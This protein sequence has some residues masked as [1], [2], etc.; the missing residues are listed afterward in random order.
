MNCDAA[1]PLLNLLVDDALDNADTVLVQEHLSNCLHCQWEWNELTWLHKRLRNF[2]NELGPSSDFQ[3]RL[4]QSLE[5]EEIKVFFARLPAAGMQYA[6]AAVIIAFTV[7]LVPTAYKRNDS[8]KLATAVSL[9]DGLTDPSKLH[10]VSDLG[11]LVKETPYN[12]K[13]INLPS[14]RLTR[15][16]VYALKNGEPI[17]RLDFSRP[18]QAAAPSKGL[19]SHHQCHFGG[20]SL[21]LAE[22]T[23]SCYQTPSGLIRTDKGEEKTIG[24][25]K[26]RVG[27]HKQYQWALWSQNGLDYFLVTKMSQAALERVVN[28]A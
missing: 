19:T 18:C 26:V 23:L 21:A 17:A 4:S 11:E 16:G 28:D 14:W 6:A 25:K 27:H 2:N 12:L 10:T 13:F 5:K 24:T 1:R 22:Q 9:I 15:V 7:L 3:A 8:Y 20:G